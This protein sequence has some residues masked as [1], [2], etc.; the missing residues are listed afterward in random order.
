LVWAK[1]R[2]RRVLRVKVGQGLGAPQSAARGD[3]TRCVARIAD[4]RQCAGAGNNREVRLRR[5]LAGHSRSREINYLNGRGRRHTRISE[6][7]SERL[8]EGATGGF[9]WSAGEARRSCAHQGLAWSAKELCCGMRPLDP[10]GQHRPRPPSP[11]LSPS[12]LPTPTP[13]TNNHQPLP[14]WQTCCRSKSSAPRPGK[15]TGQSSLSFQ[16]SQAARSHRTAQARRPKDLCCPVLTL[17]EKSRHGCLLPQTGLP[18]SPPPT[19]RPS[20]A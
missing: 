3:E 9:P 5:S 11:S 19:P 2:S 1:S 7:W 15:Q 8:G 16:W 14:T 13:N 10:R 17:P 20:S 12:L 4:G 6:T 18:S